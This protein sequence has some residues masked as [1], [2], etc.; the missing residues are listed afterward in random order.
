MMVI[1]SLL[2]SQRLARHERSCLFRRQET[3]LNLLGEGLPQLLIFVT[4]TRL[5]GTEGGRV[6]VKVSVFHRNGNRGWAF[7]MLCH[8]VTVL[9]VFLEEHM[10]RI[11]RRP[12]SR[13][14]MQ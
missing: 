2:P 9:S 3:V 7:R 4:G 14:S 5:I 6:G 11:D 13:Y 12:Q 8:R 1:V 10:F